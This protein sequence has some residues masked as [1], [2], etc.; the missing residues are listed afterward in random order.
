MDSFNSRGLC[1]LVNLKN[2]CYMNSIIQCLNNQY[3]FLLDI[4]KEHN[5]VD[6]NI[7][8][9]FINL[10]K[11]LYEKNGLIKPD[12]FLGKIKEIAYKLGN[13]EYINNSQK[14]A[15]EFLTFLLDRMGEINKQDINFKVRYNLDKYDDA[16]KKMHL[17]ALKVYSAHFKNNYTN[18]VKYFYGQFLN[19]FRD[20]KDKISYQYDP[21][22]IIQLP[23]N[24]NHGDIYDCLDDFCSIEKLN[25]NTFR[26]V[27]FY[28][29]P[30]IFI[31]QFKRDIFGSKNNTLIKFPLEL[32]MKKYYVGENE[33]K[34]ELVSV[35]N[36]I[37][38][39]N[40]GGHYTAFT[41]NLNG[42]WYEFNDTNVYS[43][44]PEKVIT[45][46]AYILFYKLKN[47]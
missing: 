4:Y 16:N 25:E 42:N 43:S 45:N 2:T 19:I 26:Q 31:I 8:N 6:E 23:I 12:I 46:N 33:K 47:I 20:N 37:G 29:F 36:H 3:H 39:N 32:D 44:S 21:Y 10:S 30:K 28:S 27:K 7:L 15:S 41:K 22:N 34:F 24:K 18:I 35:C 11:S 1:G 38:N 13:T 9:E 17:D 14:C 5:E 40:W